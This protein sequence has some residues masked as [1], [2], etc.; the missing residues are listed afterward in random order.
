MKEFIIMGIMG[1]GQNPIYPV[2]SKDG[3]KTIVPKID[4][5]KIEYEIGVEVLLNRLTVKKLEE[6]E[7]GRKRIKDI[8]LEVLIL[9]RI[10]LKNL[11][12]IKIPFLIKINFIIIKEFLGV[13]KRQEE[14]IFLCR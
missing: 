6:L 10:I 11:V 4:V 9:E 5:L 3:V 1:L 13:E 7:Q 12:F 8:R 14:N 2:Y